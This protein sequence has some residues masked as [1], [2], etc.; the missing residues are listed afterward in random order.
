MITYPT[1]ADVFRPTEKQTALWY[2]LGLIIAGSLLVALSAQ[3]AFYLPFSPVPV[4]GQTFA[5]LLVGLVL[6]SKR[7]AASMMTYLLQGAM[8]LPVFAQ[9]AF[10]L[11]TFAGPTAGYLVGFVAAAFAV[12]FLAERGWDRSPWLT[13]AAMLLGNGVIYLFGLPWLGYLVGF[14]NMLTFGFWPFLVGD[15]FKLVLAM[16]SLPTAWKFV[17]KEHN[18]PTK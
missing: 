6:G 9:G 10:G 2:D 3:L 15:T 7:G 1:Y 11:A 13:A 17:G 14:D 5:V 12:G 8:G 16:I 4:T 18:L